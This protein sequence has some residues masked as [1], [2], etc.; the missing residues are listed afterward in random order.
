M[1]IRISQK[2]TEKYPQA[3]LGVVVIKGLENNGEDEQIKKLL[4]EIQN[5]IKEEQKLENLNENPKIKEWQEVY[6]SF[7]A[8]PKK[9]RCSVEN[10]YKMI[11]EGIDLGHINKVVDIYNYISIKYMIPAGGDDLDKIEGDIMLDLA[12]GTE[13]FSQLN[14]TEIQNPHPGEVIYKD[15][16]D[17]LC[18]RWNWR[19]SDKSKMNSDTKNI[20]LVLE[21]LGSFHKQEL[22][23]IAGEM[24]DLIV[25]FCGGEKKIYFLDKDNL[26]T[27]L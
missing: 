14:T 18:R 16:K 6:Q 10:L 15:D 8:K 19:E 24:A 9:Y 3:K 27:E 23:E 4:I 22:L 11:L 20:C 25:K 21:G 26:E 5:K 1:K 12:D 7:G 2:I 17:V 13:R